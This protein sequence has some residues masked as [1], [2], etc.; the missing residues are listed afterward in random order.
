MST[1][2]IG[3]YGEISKLSLD[4]HQTPT[5]SFLLR[6]YS[7]WSVITRRP[8]KQH[9]EPEKMAELYRD[10]SVSGYLIINQH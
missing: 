7:H 10:E 9:I 5:L 6:H 4:Y 3:F 8:W 1:H 2:N